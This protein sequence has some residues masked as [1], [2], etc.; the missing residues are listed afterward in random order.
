[1][2]SAAGADIPFVH[3]GTLLATVL[4][5]LRIEKAKKGFKTGF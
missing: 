3:G 2:S 4:T 1:M 5:Y